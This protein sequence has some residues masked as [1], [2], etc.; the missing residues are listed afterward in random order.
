ME[1]VYQKQFLASFHI[2]MH[3]ASKGKHVLCAIT[4]SF[5]KGHLLNYVSC[6]HVCQANTPSI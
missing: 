3:T 2:L 5:S 1:P 6:F 4:V